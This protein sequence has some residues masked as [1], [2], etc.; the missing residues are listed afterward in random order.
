MKYGEEGRI[1]GGYA[2]SP[3]GL[4]QWIAL[5]SSR[6]AD[7]RRLVSSSALFRF[8]PEGNQ[9]DNV[10]KILHTNM[11]HRW[12]GQPNRVLTES[13][14]LAA[15][16]HEVWI[17]GPKDCVLCKRA[18]ERGLKAFD[19][20]ELR[21]GFRPASFLRDLRAMTDLMKR[22]RFDIINTHGS[23]D[24]WICAFALN[25]VEP[26]PGFFRTRHNTFPI[27]T[28]PINRWL[29]KK[30]DWVITISPQVNPLVAKNGMF[31]APRITAIYSAPDPERFKPRPVSAERRKALGIPESSPVVGVVGRLAPEKGHELLV[32]AAKIVVEQFPDT[33]FLLVGEGRSR[34]GIEEQIASLGLE[35]NFVL[36]GFSEE[37]PELV[38]LM[39]IV[40]LTPTAGE[41]LGTALLEAFCMEKPVVATEVGGTGESVRNDKT[42]FLI[43]EGP[44]DAKEKGIA[45]ALMKLLGDPGLRERMGKAGRAMVLEEFSP[46]AL[47]RKSLDLYERV[48]EEKRPLR[49]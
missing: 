22:E 16:G 49:S 12:G 6:R 23:Q 47:A 37:V 24:T 48:V 1:V 32:N 25:R 4:T 7:D 30:H 21:R 9:L 18:V 42:G 19:D 8:R 29:Y 10:L 43:K 13:V 11:H 2:P 20:L 14:H 5:G 27:A 15:L 28:H 35:N 31:P 41:S 26:K 38:A 33:R 17:A 36:T 3:G 44:V 34:K 46:E 40:A 45:E 39:D